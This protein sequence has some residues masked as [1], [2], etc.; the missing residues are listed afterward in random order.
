MPSRPREARTAAVG[1]A[2]PGV[3]QPIGDRVGGGRRTAA[4]SPPLPALCPQRAP[5]TSPS[6]DSS[7]ESGNR[8]SWLSPH[9]WEPVGRTT[10]MKGGFPAFTGCLSQGHCRDPLSSLRRESDHAVPP[11]RAPRWRP[12][13][14]AASQ[15]SHCASSCGALLAHPPAIPV[16]GHLSK[17]LHF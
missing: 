9:P 4:P 10:E 6:H 8:D 17:P 7:V 5:V 3:Q 1:Q 2:V 14:Q 13:H 11:L 12:F 15:A 16:S